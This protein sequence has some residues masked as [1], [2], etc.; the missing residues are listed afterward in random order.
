MLY[1]AETAPQE[2]KEALAAALFYLPSAST[3]SVEGDVRRLAGLVNEWVFLF[4]LCCVNL[5]RNRL[6]I[7]LGL[8]STLGEYNVPK[9]DLAGIV[10]S[11]VGSESAHHG[12]VVRLLESI[13]KPFSVPA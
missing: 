11:V 1:Q 5:P 4:A 13:Y 6:V 10:D 8:Q 9:S 12:K 3:G 2:D 7:E